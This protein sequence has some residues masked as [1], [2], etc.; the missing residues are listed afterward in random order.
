[1]IKESNFLFEIEN[2]SKYKKKE[3][4]NNITLIITST[5][6]GDADR[7]L[8]EVLLKEY[9]I[10]LA[11]LDFLPK[12]IILCNEGVILSQ[13]FSKCFAC[14][15]ELSKNDV[16]I[17]ICKTSL[18]YFGVKSQLNAANII[19]MQKIIELQMAATKLIII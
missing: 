4:A 5:S 1:M 12:N 6:F 9:L 8:G 3:E 17:H 14:L 7:I 16:E 15:N 19:S 2:I 13:D 11:N 10:A 18:K